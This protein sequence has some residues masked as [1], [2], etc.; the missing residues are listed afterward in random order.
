LP[1]GWGVI[2]AIFEIR[3]LSKSFGERHVL[4]KLSFDIQRGEILGIIGPSGAGKTTLLYLLI[5]SL[6]PSAGTATLILKHHETEKRYD[7][8][9]KPLIVNKL[10]GFASQRP[11]LYDKLTVRENLEYFASLYNLSADAIRKN[12]TVL[13]RLLDLSTSQSVLT[14]HLSGG[15]RRRLDIAC[16][17]VHDPRILILDEPTADL[18][19]VL[20]AHIWEILKRANA[21]GTTIILSSH[22]LD[23]IES[24]CTRIALLKDGMLADLDSPA[25][26][27]MKYQ[28]VSEIHLE[29]YPGQYDRLTA[30]LPGVVG[31][32]RAGTLL[33]VRTTE[34]ERT[35]P[36]LFGR[37]QESRE[38]LID[39][40]I[41]KPRLDDVF[42]SIYR[43]EP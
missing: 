19:P 18:D 9:T 35:L 43:R 20:R 40:R 24:S 1:S 11:S 17:L 14:E 30:G 16:A 10:F 12:T 37:L 5:G 29:S 8:R 26:L 41:A 28:R 32:Q 3:N 23:E 22:H 21:R 13:L 15:M 7:T 39:L 27:R 38:H 31:E 2:D 36:L 4:R 33:I 42:T 34:P 25:K 6:E